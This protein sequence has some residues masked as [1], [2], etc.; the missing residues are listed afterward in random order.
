MQVEFLNLNNYDK[1][2]HN[3][4]AMSFY[5]ELEEAV[6]QAGTSFYKLQFATGIA[7][8]HFSNWKKGRRSPS[9]NDLHKLAAV[10]ELGVTFPQLWTWRAI[11]Q[12]GED[13]MRE[14]A[15]IVL[16]MEE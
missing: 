8:S 13:V 3:K 16:E 11:D 1:Q 4:L 7:S 9:D 12:Y 5:E 2:A 10:P 14:A 15:K 6:S